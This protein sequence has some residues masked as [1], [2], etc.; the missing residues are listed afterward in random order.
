MKAITL[1]LCLCALCACSSPYAVTK[2]K[3]ELTPNFRI[4][5]QMYPVIDYLYQCNAD[6]FTYPPGVTSETY[7]DS[8]LYYTTAV[9]VGEYMAGMMKTG[10]FYAGRKKK[11]K[12]RYERQGF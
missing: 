4:A 1:L 8:V 11:E 12:A 5:G 2:L 9:Q 10:Q 3:K 6:N 7:R